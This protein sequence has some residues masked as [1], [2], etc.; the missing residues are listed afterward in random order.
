[1]QINQRRQCCSFFMLYLIPASSTL[2]VCV[3]Y[4]CCG[5]VVRAHEP[6]PQPLRL[7][8]HTGVTV[9]YKSCSNS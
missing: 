9:L 6:I 5:C 8:A 3:L 2:L 7:D 1:M 4:L